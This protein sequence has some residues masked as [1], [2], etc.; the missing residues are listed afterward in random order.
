MTFRDDSQLQLF[1]HPIWI[2]MK[3][4][5]ILLV[6]LLFAF[7]AIQAQTFMKSYGGPGD[8]Y[9]RWI[10]QTP[11]SGY[12]IAGTSSYYTNGL[13]DIYLVR[14]DRYGDTLWTKHYGGTANELF[15]SVEVCPDSGFIIAGTTYSFGTGTPTYSNWFVI[16]TDKDGNQ[17]WTN[18]YGTYSN[19]LMFHAR[20]TSDGGFL[21]MGYMDIGGWAKGT[22]IKTNSTGYAMWTSYMGSS[23][24][25]YAYESI[26]EANGQFVCSGSTLSGTFQVLLQRLSASG[27]VITSKT[28]HS[29]GQYADGG[30]SMVPAHGGGYMVLGIYGNYGSYNVWLL[31]VDA[32]LDTLWTKTLPGYLSVPQLWSKDVSIN[33]VSDGYI[34]CGTGINAGNSDIKLIRV[35]TAGNLI[36]TKFYGG[37][38]EH[39]GYKAITT[40]EGGIA[41]CGMNYNGGNFYDFFVMVADSAGNIAPPT[42]P[43]ANAG[44]GGNICA[45]DSFPVPNASASNFNA[46]HWTTS[47]TGYFSDTTILNPVYYPSAN[48]NTTGT[49]ILTLSAM[50][51]GYSN[52]VSVCTLTIHP[53]PIITI[54]GLNSDYCLDAAPVSVTGQPLGGNF[55]GNGISPQGLFN[56]LSAGTGSHTV[57]YHYTDPASQC[58]GTDSVVISVHPVPVAAIITSSPVALCPGDSALL[59]AT[60]ST[61][62]NCHWLWNSIPLPGAID[63]ILFAGTTGQYQAV[64]TTIFGCTDTS[65]IVEVVLYQ[66]PAITLGHDTSICSGDQILIDAGSGYSAYLWSNGAVS[67]SVLIDSSGVGNGFIDVWVRIWDMNGC[68]NGDTV[69]ITFVD[70]TGLLSRPA[71]LPLKVFPNPF[72]N[73]FTV[74]FDAGSSLTIDYMLQDVQGQTVMKQELV[75]SP[76]TISTDQLSPG[77]YFLVI[78]D[79]AQTVR[80]KIIRY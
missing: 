78:S 74:S 10:T 21:L 50:A 19:D 46:L 37:P 33:R 75:S 66:K 15:A 5:F 35:D 42:P 62:S 44:P 80:H 73:H 30:L 79:G 16:K 22:V 70:C 54:S 24:N 43:L 27:S 55:S 48:D 45:G 41:A 59:S 29:S 23:G 20:P 68:E 38:G 1:L 8:E 58:S 76:Y 47:G 51:S 53:L 18:T 77:I 49:I 60:I 67:Q 64:A 25:S 2:F 34:L 9:G 69:T 36:W 4:R 63:T 72:R 7:G 61:G 57:Y 71:K 26:E 28:Y 65:G 13:R 11:D 17:V 56:P 12:A 31:R 6:C 32:N 3:S 14:I 39:Y 52:A 40:P